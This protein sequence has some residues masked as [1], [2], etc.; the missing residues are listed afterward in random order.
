MKSGNLN[1]LEPSGPL[2]ALNGTALPL[3]QHVSTQFTKPKTQHLYVNPAT[4]QADTKEMCCNYGMLDD[5]FL[6]L[7]ARAMCPTE[8]TY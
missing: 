1:F 4:G 8:F 7:L 3:P 2:K 5:I 6:L